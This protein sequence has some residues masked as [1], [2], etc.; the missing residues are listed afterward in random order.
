M[1]VLDRWRLNNAR[2]RRRNEALLAGYRLHVGPLPVD[3][4][5]QSVAAALDLADLTLCGSG[6]IAVA[7]SVGTTSGDLEITLN[8][9][10]LVVPDLDAD[11]AY[12]FRIL[13]NAALT[14]QSLVAADMTVYIL[15]DWRRLNQAVISTWS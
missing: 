8:G 11:E 5:A 12:A 9:Q 15:D 14:V 6:T 2:S 1:A 10:A 4:G 7:L 3:A 13:Q